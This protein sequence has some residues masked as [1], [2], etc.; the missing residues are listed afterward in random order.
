MP[1]LGATST[2]PKLRA[3]GPRLREEI[4][5]DGNLSRKAIKK[6]NQVREA[7]LAGPDRGYPTGTLS[8]ELPGAMRSGEAYRRNLSQVC[9]QIR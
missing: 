2:V 6:G 1:P 7:Y 3:G 8:P 4:P 5:P 9:L